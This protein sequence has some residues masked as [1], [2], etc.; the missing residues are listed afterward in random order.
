MRPDVSSTLAPRVVDAVILD[1]G[2]VLLYPNLDWLAAEAGARGLALTRDQLF[3]AYYRTIFEADQ[4]EQ[5]SRPSLALTSLEIRTWIFGRM[6]EHA[7]ASPEGA[8]AAGAALAERSLERY[9]RESD[10]Y[11]W[12]MPGLRE[13]LEGLRAAGFRLGVAS[14]NDGALRE[15]LAAVDCLDLFEALMDS[16]VEGVAK[17]DPELPLRAARALGV[18]PARCLF[19]GDLDRIDGEAGRAAGMAVALLDPLGQERPSGVMLLPSLEAIPLHFSAGR[20]G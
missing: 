15:Q 2:G 5:T 19:V 13:R 17:P 3:P 4:L 11:Y 10:I 8:L 6:L 12:S 20:P 7:G 1:A 16:G 18:P 14:N 9:P